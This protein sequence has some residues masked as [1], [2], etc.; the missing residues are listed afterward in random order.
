MK[1]L[2]EQVVQFERSTFENRYEYSTFHPRHS[3]PL[4]LTLILNLKRTLNSIQDTK[5]EK[6]DS[7]Y[8]TVSGQG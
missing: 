2:I 1:K 8:K 5:Y 4:L 7:N 6:L 3:I